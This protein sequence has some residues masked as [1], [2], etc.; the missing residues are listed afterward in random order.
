VLDAARS[1]SKR[2]SAEQAMNLRFYPEAKGALAM[3]VTMRR[4]F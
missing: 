4:A 1:A 2:R 3:R